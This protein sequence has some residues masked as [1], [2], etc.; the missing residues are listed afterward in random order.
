MEGKLQE[1]EYMTE[2]IF[3]ADTEG[4]MWLLLTAYNKM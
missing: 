1:L 2:D 3:R 4:A